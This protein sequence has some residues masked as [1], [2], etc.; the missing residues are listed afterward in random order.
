ME[1]RMK[2]LLRLVLGC[3]LAVTLIASYP[4]IQQHD[5]ILFAGVSNQTDPATSATAN[6]DANIRG[7]PSTAF[8]IV[9]VV[10]SG[11][12]L[13]VTG[14]NEAGDW[15]QLAAGEWIAAFLV[16]NAPDQLPLAAPD[17]AAPAP[18][19]TAEPVEEATAA[20]A[21]EATAAPVEEATTAPAEEATTAPAEEATTAPAEEATTAPAEEATTAPVADAGPTVNRNANLRAGPS[22]DTA[23][24][25][26]ATAGQIVT[27]LGISADG[28]WY[29]LQSG[30]WIAAFLVSGAP[31]QLPLAS[32]ATAA[33]A[34]T[35]APTEEATATP[36]EATAAP[37]EEATAAPATEATAIPAEEAA[38]TLAVIEEATPTPVPPTVTPPPP[39]LAPAPIAE[40]TAVPTPEVTIPNGWLPITDD[41]LGYSLAVPPGWT[42]LDLRGA[43]VAQ[44]AAVAGQAEGLAELQAFLETAEGQAVGTVAI[45]PDLFGMMQGLIPPALNVSVIPVPAAFSEADVV[46]LVNANMGIADQFEDAEIEP[47]TLETVNNLT[48][49]V[50]SASA[51]LSDVGLNQ[52]VIVRAIGLL[53][54][55]SVYLLTLVVRDASFDTTAT[56]FDQIIGTFRPE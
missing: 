14:Q 26:G 21:E 45:Q 12:V 41:R 47:A 18:A 54:N 39:T 36:A 55:D 42:E 53:A 30:E 8:P 52:T 3:T 29:L 48:A 40:A 34:A 19:A 6:R 9:R 17:S 23:I 28:G 56:I 43:Q 31:D 16:D 51:G 46:A 33:P 49:V 22:T 24:V 32:P 4:L 15:Y 38:P 10:R 37:V 2:R 13:E 7:G 25:G 27:P 35:T 20:P 44:L 50:S 1:K 5:G 11:D